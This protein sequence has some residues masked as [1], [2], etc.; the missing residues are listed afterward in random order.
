MKREIFELGG[1]TYKVDK[2]KPAIERS[3]LMFVCSCGSEHE[4]TLYDSGC[5]E[6][7]VMSKFDSM[8]VN[9]VKC[10]ECGQLYLETE[11][12]DY[13]AMVYQAVNEI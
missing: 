4:I 3:N 7:W 5:E 2:E 1:T 8:E 10:S 9:I 13:N 12:N 6:E 11:K